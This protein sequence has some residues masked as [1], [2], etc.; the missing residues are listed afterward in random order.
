[1]RQLGGALT[2]PRVGGGAASGLEAQFAMFAVGVTPTADACELVAAHVAT[3]QR[4]MGRWEARRAC[5]NFAERRRSG[6]ELFGEAVH[7]RLRDVKRAYDPDDVI[8]A[9]H[10]VTSTGID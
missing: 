6:G 9:N 4:A 1:V 7:R 8:Q 5:A 2:R 10:P 3:L